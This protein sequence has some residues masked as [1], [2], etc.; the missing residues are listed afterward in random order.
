MPNFLFDLELS[1][2]IRVDAAN[3]TE[4]RAMLAK[5]LDCADANFGAWEWGDPITGEVSLTEKPP[6]LAEIDGEEPRPSLYS[7]KGETLFAEGQAFR[8]FEDGARGYRIARKRDGAEAIFHG[9]D[10]CERFRDNYKG[11]EFA[12]D[13]PTDAAEEADEFGAWCEREGELTA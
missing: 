11:D 2:A 7:K 8:I 9:D 13:N 6:V 12:E 3:E 4:A 10:S 5:A 1:A